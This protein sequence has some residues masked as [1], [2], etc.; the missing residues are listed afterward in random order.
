MGEGF[1]GFHLEF[2]C[3][4][5]LNSLALCR[6]A[7]EKPK[8]GLL[9]VEHLVIP[10]PPYLLGG[11]DGSIDRMLLSDSREVHQGKPVLEVPNQLY[12]NKFRLQMGVIIECSFDM[13]CDNKAKWSLVQ[14][15]GGISNNILMVITNLIII[16]DNYIDL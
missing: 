12:T 1:Y 4:E 10:A 9:D 14:I 16:L 7:I 11:G 2:F 5:G 13:I 15:I 6:H 8:E 3:F